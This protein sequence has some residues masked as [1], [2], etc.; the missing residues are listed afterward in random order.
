MN[1]VYRGEAGRMKSMEVAGDAYQVGRALGQA[2]A[3]A[4]HDTVV[5]LGRFRALRH[6]SR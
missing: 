4:F 2:A 3:R 5:H 6:L 1:I